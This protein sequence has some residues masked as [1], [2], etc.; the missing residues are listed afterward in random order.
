MRLGLSLSG[1]GFRATLFHLGVVRFLRDA[2]LL[3]HVETLC[4]VSGGSVLAAHMVQ[5]W[6]EYIDADDEVFEKAARQLIHF[7]QRD[8]RGQIVRRAPWCVA[9]SF[10]PFGR[11][12]LTDILQNRYAEL[13]QDAYLSQLRS[14]NNGNEP[15]EFHILSTNLTTGESWSFAE[16]GIWVEE[17]NGPALR[18]TKV[19]K[20]SLAVA[21]SS[22]YPA[23][24]SPIQVDADTLQINRDE[25]GIPHQALT[26]GGVYDNLGVRKFRQLQSARNSKP[27]DAIIVSDAGGTLEWE[28]SRNYSSIMGRSM[29]TAS[30]LMQRVEDL[31]YEIHGLP[32]DLNGCGS[33]ADNDSLANYVVVPI[34]AEIPDGHDPEGIHLNLQRAARRV[35]TDLDYFSPL[36][37]RHLVRHGYSMARFQLHHA[38]SPQANVPGKILKSQPWN[39]FPP[40][41]LLTEAQQEKAD[42][43]DALKM[44]KS[45]RIALRIFSA[46][47][48]FSWI[49]LSVVVVAIAIPTAFIL[50]QFDEKKATIEQQGIQ[51]VQLDRMRG[52]DQSRGDMAEVANV[53]QLA[54]DAIRNSPFAKPFTV[55]VSYTNYLDEWIDAL[56]EGERGI[57]ENYRDDPDSSNESQD[58]LIAQYEKVRDAVDRTG[59]G[60][61]H[62][63]II[64]RPNSNIALWDGVLEFGFPEDSTIITLYFD[65][66]GNDDVLALRFVQPPGDNRKGRSFDVQFESRDRAYEGTVFWDAVGDPHLPDGTKIKIGT[67]TMAPN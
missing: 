23:L 55:K 32:R 60:T 9:S 4:S 63:E 34:D 46:R 67:I 57:V 31:E 29:R 28:T 12:S 53:I 38:K 48:L 20:T 22:A 35:R 49:N 41:K 42:T 3:P 19:V 50:N 36:E 14:N 5:H 66:E 37:V 30:I 24:F 11:T 64:E 8:I 7:T 1:G 13:Y 61:A 16:P 39:P 15:P 52:I 6:D 27:F 18:S 44:D 2:G 45:S 17:E 54:S 58:P 47:D 62:A 21:A 25:F 51:L 10:L 40:P 56:P 26:D 43:N 59:S 33:Q 65:G